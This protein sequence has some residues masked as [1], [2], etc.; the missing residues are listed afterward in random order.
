M[1]PQFQN[2]CNRYVDMWAM[3]GLHPM[4]IE[5][6]QKLKTADS[7]HFTKEMNAV[8]T[9]SELDSDDV[10]QQTHLI[11]VRT[12][13]WAPD[14]SELN[15]ALKRIK[16]R[17]LVE[18][19]KKIKR[20]GRLNE[21]QNEVLQ[22]QTAT[23]DVL[24]MEVGDI[25]KRRLVLK[26]FKNSTQRMR[27]CGTIEEVTTSEI[28]NSIGSKRN[29]ITLMVN[30]PDVQFVTTIQENH[31]TLR[32]PATF[33]FCFHDQGQMWHINLKQRW[34]SLGPDFDLLIN[35][36]NVGLVDGKLMCFGS[37]SYIDMENHPLLSDTNF[38]NLITLFTASIGYHKAMRKSIGRRV[39]ATLA[40]QSYRHL[41]EDEEL[42]L[43]H[44]GRAAA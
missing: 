4:N 16:K 37:D 41:I 44:N 25:E 21:K 26:L 36:Q 30:L 27:W 40:G 39:K 43:R 13:V 8:G 3:P 42:R 33:S 15:S 5:I 22:E 14:Q 31:R 7:N 20:T 2:Q 17:R 19:R 11:G 6:L 34:V 10:W 9:V 35:G 38:L 1:A 12:D 24:N 18:L 23:D 28:H 29:L 32:Y